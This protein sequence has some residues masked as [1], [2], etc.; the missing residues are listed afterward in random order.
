MFDKDDIRKQLEAIAHASDFVNRAYD[1]VDL[2]NSQGVGLESVDIILR[3]IEDNPSLD[4]GAPGPLGHFVEQFY[5]RGYEARLIKSI[6]RKPVGLT[7]SL[8]NGVINGTIDNE[9]RQRLIS[10]LQSV[11]SNPHAT[12]N[13]RAL[14]IRYLGWLRG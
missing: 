1:L 13:G 2:W 14:A 6:Q 4:C 3:F 9:E 7:V 5:R 12:D 10:V 11:T 8:L